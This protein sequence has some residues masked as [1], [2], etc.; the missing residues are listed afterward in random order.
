HV[1]HAHGVEQQVG[2]AGQRGAQNLVFHGGILMDIPGND[3]TCWGRQ[4]RRHENVSFTRRSC[5]AV[6][7]R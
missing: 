1:D 6:S 7:C 2:K 3:S 5:F 4:G